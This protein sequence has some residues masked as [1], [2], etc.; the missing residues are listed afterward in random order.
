MPIPRDRLNTVVI[1]FS[2]PDIAISLPVIGKRDEPTAIRMIPDA[3][4]TPPSAPP[5]SIPPIRNP[6]PAISIN[7]IRRLACSPVPINP[8]TKNISAGGMAIRLVDDIAK[9]IENIPIVSNT[10]LTVGSES[11]LKILQL[12]QSSAYSY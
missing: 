3:N 10:P 2:A 9:I 6:I 12:M 1:A 11:R 8:S 4:S 7:T 5:N